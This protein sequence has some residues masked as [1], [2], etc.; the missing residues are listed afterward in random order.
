MCRVK[1]VSDMADPPPISDST[2]KQR[3]E[4]FTPYLELFWPQH[5][6]KTVI[7]HDTERLITQS[8]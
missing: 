4:N 6:F 8:N 3:A 5:N 2:A 1:V 7:L